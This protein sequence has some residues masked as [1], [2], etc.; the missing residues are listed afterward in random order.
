[1]SSMRHPEAR[2]RGLGSAHH[3]LAHWWA[4]RLTA[5]ALI[6]LTL[7]FVA[8]LCV[9]VAHDYR[10]AVTS[11]HSPVNAI[12]MILL[13][14]AGLHHGQLGLQVV[15]E[16]YTGGWVRT[17]LIILVKFAAVALGVACIFAVAKVAFA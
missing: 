7:W 2:V 10:A 15:I 13:V 11:L 17:T 4:Q 6:P 16:D 8:Y 3:G 14:L 1:M 5:L 12:L 9:T